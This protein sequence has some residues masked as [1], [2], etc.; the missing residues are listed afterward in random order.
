MKILEM[1]SGGKQRMP[2]EMDSTLGV[3][4]KVV[5]TTQCWRCEGPHNHVIRQ[6]NIVGSQIE[7]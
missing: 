7:F 3:S 2:I 4:L 6:Q 1:S 5:L